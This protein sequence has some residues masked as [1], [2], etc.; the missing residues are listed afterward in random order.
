[1]T[2]PTHL[3]LDLPRLGAEGTAHA[4]G[5]APSRPL[6]RFEGAAALTLVAAPRNFGTAPQHCRDQRPVTANQ[7]PFVPATKM[8]GVRQGVGS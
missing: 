4:R 5:A 6:G 7:A 8:T 2:L 1:M 3:R